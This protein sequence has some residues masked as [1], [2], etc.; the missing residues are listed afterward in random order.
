MGF[1]G[2]GTMGEGPDEQGAV[3]ELVTERLFQ[4]V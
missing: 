4:I 1:V 3:F 2:A